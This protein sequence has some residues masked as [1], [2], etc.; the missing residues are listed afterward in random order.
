MPYRKWKW[1]GFAA[2]I[3]LVA[4]LFYSTRAETRIEAMPSPPGESNLGI[5]VLKVSAAVDSLAWSPDTN[6]LAIGTKPNA[7]GHGTSAI[8]LW[9]LEENQLARN[10]YETS[11]VISSVAFRRTEGS[12]HVDNGI[13]D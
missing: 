8:V 10:L 2:L 5:Q 6:M 7:E 3:L 11:E 12:S 13:P 1:L 4:G 9:D